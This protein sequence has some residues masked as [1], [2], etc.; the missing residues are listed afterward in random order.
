MAR[1][2][3]PEEAK[4]DSK[5]TLYCTEEEKKAI[6]EAALRAGQTDSAYLLE[7][8]KEKRRK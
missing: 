5:I 2:K 3:K 8:F 7:M 4:R 6:K 1:P